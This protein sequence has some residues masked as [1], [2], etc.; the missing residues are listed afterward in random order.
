MSWKPTGYTSAS[1]YLLVRDAEATLRFLEAVFSAERLRVH[2]RPDGAGIAHAEARVDDTVIMMGEMPEAG[3][4]HVHVYVPDAEGTFARALA[5]GGTVVQPLRR[6]GD[7][8]VRGGVADGNG[9]VWWIA[10]QDD[11]PADPA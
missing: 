9:A 1:P 2:P 11:T 4:A 6:S 10:A 7:G 8:D 5:A 3:D